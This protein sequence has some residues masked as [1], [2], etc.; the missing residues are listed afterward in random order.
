MIMSSKHS[1]SLKCIKYSGYIVNAHR[2]FSRAYRL[3]TLLPPALAACST[4]T[5][6]GCWFTHGSRLHRTVGSMSTKDHDLTVDHAAAALLPGEAPGP[7]RHER[8]ARRRRLLQPMSERRS[9]RARR[10]VI[11]SDAQRAQRDSAAL[12][13]PPH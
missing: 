5:V 2:F 1:P 8:K 6:R 4:I 3:F 9:E 10:A 13:P 7:N 12:P 11:G